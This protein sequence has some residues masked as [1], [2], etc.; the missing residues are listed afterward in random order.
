MM[1]PDDQTINEY[2]AGTPEGVQPVLRRMREVIHENAP[3]A[4]EK[5]AWSMPTF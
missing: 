5:I 3:E 4:S 2:I 1:K